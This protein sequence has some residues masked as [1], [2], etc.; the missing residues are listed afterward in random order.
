[1]TLPGVVAGVFSSLLIFRGIHH[2]SKV[3]PHSTIY[4]IEYGCFLLRYIPRN[5]ELTPR[6]EGILIHY[7]CFEHHEQWWEVSDSRFNHNITKYAKDR[8]ICCFLCRFMLY[9]MCE[10]N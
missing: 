1:M 9:L 5:L 8:I 10:L 2:R 4:N 6:Q 3:H 7:Q